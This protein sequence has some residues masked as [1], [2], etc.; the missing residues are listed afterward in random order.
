M[1]GRRFDGIKIT[2]ACRKKV[3]AVK[4]IEEGRTSAGYPSFFFFD[5]VF[6]FFC[7]NRDNQDVRVTVSYLQYGK[8]P[9]S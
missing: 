6:I 9:S 1:G 4:G 7:H 8:S 5:F 3:H 2:T